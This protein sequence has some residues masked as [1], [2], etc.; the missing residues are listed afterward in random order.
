MNLRKDFWLSLTVMSC[1]V[2]ILMIPACA[3]SFLA[4]ARWKRESAE[5]EGPRRL[6]I[7]LRVPTLLIG[8]GSATLAWCSYRRYTDHLRPSE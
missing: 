8:L 2:A 4:A 7:D 5:S 1:F 3:G 6:R